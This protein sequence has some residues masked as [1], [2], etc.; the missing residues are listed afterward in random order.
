MDACWECP[1]PKYLEQLPPTPMGRCLRKYCG[2][3]RE[4]HT[5]RP[6]EAVRPPPDESITVHTPCTIC[7]CGD[8][9]IGRDL[10][11]CDN[12]SHAPEKHKATI[13]GWTG[14]SPQSFWNMSSQNIDSG[15]KTWTT[16]E[17]SW[18]HICLRVEYCCGLKLWVEFWN[19][20]GKMS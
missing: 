12:C 13:E 14:W 5:R 2:H 20:V 16:Q 10:T 9:R 15:P 6:Q 1:C 11:K 17:T 19:R 7:N 3:I 8:F 18:V 4:A